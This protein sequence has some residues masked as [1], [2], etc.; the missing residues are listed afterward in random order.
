M[1]KKEWQREID[2]RRHEEA[3]P[4][5]D[6]LMS[7]YPFTLENLDGEE[8]KPIDGFDGY[9]VSTF[10]RIKSFKRCRA[11]KSVGNQLDSAG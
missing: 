6:A 9:Q 8:W 5:Y 11:G 10:G 4:A 2:R 1:D 7:C 3:K